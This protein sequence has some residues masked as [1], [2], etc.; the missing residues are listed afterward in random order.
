MIITQRPHVDGDS[1]TAIQTPVHY[2]LARENLKP[3]RTDGG[4]AAILEEAG[5]F[6]GWTGMQLVAIADLFDLPLRQPEAFTGLMCPL[7]GKMWV[8]HPAEATYAAMRLHRVHRIATGRGGSAKI[9]SLVD[10]LKET[11]D[12]L[13]GGKG[14][15]NML[16]RISELAV[17]I[18]SERAAW[19]F[20][21]DG[22]KWHWGQLVH[23]SLRGVP[24]LSDAFVRF[25][26]TSLPRETYTDV[27]PVVIELMRDNG[28]WS[29]MKGMTDTEAGLMKLRAGSLLRRLCMGHFEANYGIDRDLDVSG[30]GSVSIS[31]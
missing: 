1:N 31:A 19:H 18:P 23:E 30:S 14:V 8:E 17:G 28:R 5:R 20:L 24:W 10:T 4:D 9:A 2:L 25:A 12:G 29:I 22:D 21:D 13:P 7:I 16:S 26:M 11:L 6:N 3:L 15:S 27:K